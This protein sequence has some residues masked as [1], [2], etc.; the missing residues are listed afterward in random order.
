MGISLEAKSTQVLEDWKRYLLIS[1]PDCLDVTAV[2]A[3]TFQPYLDMEC[4]KYLCKP[5]AHLWFPEGTQDGRACE[6]REFWKYCIVWRHFCPPQN[7]GKSLLFSEIHQRLPPLWMV[8][9][10]SSGHTNVIISPFSA[11]FVN[12]NSFTLLK[13]WSTLTLLSVCACVWFFPDS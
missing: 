6:I 4:K 8:K 13:L 3:V 12:S 10:Q 2:R 11:K 1:W 5:E 7:G 9:S